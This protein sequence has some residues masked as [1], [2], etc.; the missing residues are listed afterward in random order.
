MITTFLLEMELVLPLLS[1]T[2]G[3]YRIA[4]YLRLLSAVPTIVSNVMFAF[5][6]L[7]EGQNAR[8][9]CFWTSDPNP[10]VQWLKDDMILIESDLPDN[11]RISPLANGIGSM[12]RIFSVTPDDAG[13]YTCYVTNPVGNDF[14][15]ERLKVRGMHNALAGYQ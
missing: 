11:I 14:I 9:T 10:T 3:I 12:L 5:D 15:V 13:K 2:V 7:E 4:F 6:N 8:A 1:F